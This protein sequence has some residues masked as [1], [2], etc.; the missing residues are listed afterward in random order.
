MM[1]VD[2]GS[3]TASAASP[4][5]PPT[6][7]LAALATLCQP[8]EAGCGAPRASG[9]PVDSVRSESVSAPWIALR[10]AAEI[11]D[12]VRLGSIPIS[13]SIGEPTTLAMRAPTLGR[14]I[15]RTASVRARTSAACMV[16][17]GAP[18]QPGRY[19]A[20]NRRAAWCPMTP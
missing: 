18:I 12:D 7:P 9:P 16:I 19:S 4:K 14:S 20:G 13:R 8:L 3:S 5:A 1:V 10:A 6:A 2:T 17:V 11:T 15:A